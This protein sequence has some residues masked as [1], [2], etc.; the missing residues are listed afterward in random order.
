MNRFLAHFLDLFH[1]KVIGVLGG[2]Q[3][4]GFQPQ[5]DWLPAIAY[6]A[7]IIPLLRA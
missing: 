3:G 1:W 7:A 5:Y 4:P 2:R 6:F